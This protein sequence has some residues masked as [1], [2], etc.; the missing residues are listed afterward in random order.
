M[1]VRESKTAKE[2]FLKFK[3]LCL[4]SIITRESSLSRMR[5]IKFLIPGL[6][7][8]FLF[9][10]ITRDWQEIAALLPSF[11][12]VPLIIAFFFLLTIY[13]EAAFGW[14][15][16]LKKIGLNFSLRNSLY[17]WILSTT[18]RYIPGVIWQYIGRVEL[19]NRVGKL[20]RNKVVASLLFEIF[21]GVTSALFIALFGVP[22]LLSKNIETQFWIFPLVLPLVVFHSSI[23]GRAIAILS[24]ILNKDIKYKIP[25]LGTLQTLQIFPIFALNFFLNGLA[26]FFLIQSIYPNHLSFNILE[27]SGFYALSW[28]LGYVAIFAPAG[29]GVT[30]AT[31]AYFLSLLLPVSV[32]SLVALAYRFFLTLA[33][34]LVFLITLKL[35]KEAR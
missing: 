19:A 4:P 12:I 3:I 17:V 5:Y 10:N 24:K 32:A 28:F 7:V 31:L 22:F 1:E 21:L 11:K 18:S 29:L 8:V 35:G 2:I 6:L 23:S 13:P 20:P 33:E 30:E 14:H 15:T 27:L 25:Y 16:V 34:V 9:F 26:L